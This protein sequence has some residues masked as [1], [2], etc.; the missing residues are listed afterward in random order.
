MEY[1]TICIINYVFQIPYDKKAFC[2]FIRFKAQSICHHVMKPTLRHCLDEGNI[3]YI[4]L[5]ISD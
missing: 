2:L 4:Y 3:D 5:A 1:I